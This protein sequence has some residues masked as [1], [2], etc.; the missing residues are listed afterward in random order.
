MRQK[1]FLLL[2][3]AL[4]SNANYP[5]VDYFFGSIKKWTN[6]LDQNARINSF[7][8]ARKRAVAQIRFDDFIQ[9]IHQE[10]HIIFHNS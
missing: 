6:Q 5:L 4:G 2:S 3:H 1:C 10:R 8:S 7:E 9:D